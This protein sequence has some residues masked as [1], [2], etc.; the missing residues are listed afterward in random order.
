MIVA[1]SVVMA[2]VV[3]AAGLYTIH[4][5]ERIAAEGEGRSG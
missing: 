3:T 2:A 5:E 4:T 1:M